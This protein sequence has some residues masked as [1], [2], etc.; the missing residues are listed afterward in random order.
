M[1]TKRISPAAVQALKEALVA[2]YWYKSDL[3]SFLTSC[4][5][6]SHV[7]ANVNWDEYK[8]GIVASVVDRLAAHQDRYGGDLL[9]L[10]SEVS[11]M[12]N[13]SHLERLDDGEAKATM[14]Q[15]AVR[16]LQTF[17]VPHEQILAEQKAIEARRKATF[18]AL[19][20]HEAV[21]DKLTNLQRT[22][23][24]LISTTEPQKRGYRLETVLNELFTLFDLDPKASFRV[25]GEQIDG[26]F[27][28]DGTDYLLEG[29][30]QTLR[31]GTHDLDA[32]KGKLS[33]KLDNTLGLFL[34]I[35]GFEANAIALHSGAR[36][37]MILMDGSDLMAVL[38]GRIDLL[39]LLLRK[40]RHAAQTGQ[41]FLEIR[42]ILG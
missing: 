21:R 14:A 4:I 9:R 23:F 5:T 8:R 36:P 18:E 35:N 42:E 32:F 29:K 3:R 41:V 34:S 11:A 15:A 7:L 33:R 30:W 37:S 27:T 40:R 1:T 39:Q 24:A 6:D 38:E 17:V 31:V 25:V 28:F 12:T 26:A 2:I 10:L 13:F 22:F 19:L 20:Q 16:A